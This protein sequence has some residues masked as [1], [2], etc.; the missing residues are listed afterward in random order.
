MRISILAACCAILTASSAQA[1]TV[2]D[3]FSSTSLG[4][5]YADLPEGLST[6]ADIGGIGGTRAIS[7]NSIH[8]PFT[9]EDIRFRVRATSGELQVRAEDHMADLTLTYDAGGAGLS[10]DQSLGTKFSLNLDT[11]TLGFGRTTGATMTITDGSGEVATVANLFS[12][13]QNVNGTVLVLDFANADF[14]A[15]NSLIDLSDIDVIALTYQSGEGE[16]FNISSFVTNVQAVPT[17]GPVGGALAI[18]G[19]A[20]ARRRR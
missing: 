18:A 20:A 4:S 8:T 6:F 14:I 3:D 1:I 2:I 10:F 19:L 9:S 5:S 7:F 17:P 15:N 11:D 12:S 13:F 16:D